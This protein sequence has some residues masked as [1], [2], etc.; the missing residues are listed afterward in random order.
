MFHF[1]FSFIIQLYVSNQISFR[2][3]VGTD[4]FFLTSITFRSNI[5]AATCIELEYLK[6]ES[7]LIMQPAPSS[8][9]LGD[10]IIF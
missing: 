1:K 10:T 7:E 6:E 9:I 4:F 3:E 2:P 5:G 8:N